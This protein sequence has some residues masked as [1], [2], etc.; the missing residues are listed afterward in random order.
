MRPSE[1]GNADFSSGPRNAVIDIGSNTV[2]MVIYGG[3]ARAPAVLWNEKVTARLGRDMAATGRLSDEAMATAL[4]GLARF[5][6]LLAMQGITDVETVATA[7]VR[8]AENGAQFLEQ[9]RATGLMPR[10]LTGIE[11]AIIGAQGVLGAF[12]AANGVVADLGGGSLELTRIADRACSEGISL[13]LGTLRL[14]SL[15][16]AGPDVFAQE[17][18]RLLHNTPWPQSQATGKAVHDLYMVGGTSRS[19]AIYGLRNAKSALDD[20]HGLSLNGADAAALMAAISSK[21]REQL[22]KVSGIASMRAAVLPDAA[23]LL[24]LLIAHIRPARVIFSAWGL[25]EGLLMRRMEPVALMQDPL[26]AGVA[27]YAAP[28]GGRPELAARIAGWTADARPAQGQGE[29]RLRLAATML[30]LASMQI[31]PNLRVAHGLNWALHKRWINLDA[32]GRAMLA[33]ALCGNTG[34]TSAPGELA[35]LADPEQLREA[36]CWG[37]AIRLFRRIGANALDSLNTTRLRAQ[38]GRLELRFSAHSAVLR[39]RGVEKD[40][41][42]LADQL[43][44]EPAIIIMPD[45]RLSDDGPG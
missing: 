1:R 25:R 39:N 19:V 9:V 13:P 6:A 8:D 41:D 32:S 28:R 10:L 26:L 20:P 16:A 15:R 42:K 30:A 29:E 14:E 2:R 35:G 7:A 43:G 45:A 4:A 37:L 17:V 12:P 22:A 34:A 24:D 33:A 21:T 18:G 36:I 40:L 38:D 5:A 3:A 27:A 23:A 31:E 44:M 11:E